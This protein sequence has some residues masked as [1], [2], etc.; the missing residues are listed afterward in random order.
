M[1]P[2]LVGEFKNRAM[3]DTFGQAGAG[4]FAVPSVIE[5]EARPHYIGGI[6]QFPGGA[7][8]CRLYRAEIYAM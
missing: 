3:M 8:L 7:H 5:K 1:R 4:L 2:K 6:D